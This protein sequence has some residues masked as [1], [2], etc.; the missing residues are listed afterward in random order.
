MT[1]S[2]LV[3]FITIITASGQK[4]SLS[5][6]FL[7]WAN[8][9]TLNVEVGYGF[10]NKLSADLHIRYNPW[11][12]HNEGKGYMQNRLQSYSVG[13]KYWPWYIY[14]GWF[15]GSSFQYSQYNRGGILSPLTREGDA[16]GVS[17]SGG[18]AYMINSRL[19]LLFGVSFWPGYEYYRLYSCPKCGDII[20]ESSALFFRLNE[21]MLQL[22][23]I[24]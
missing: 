20:E 19:N 7:E 13:V 15:V 17:L 14:S 22:T 6:N 21:V 9:A 18:Y 16:V 3:I 5:T 23:Y 4:L 10:T 1:L 12:F 2:T 11:Q 24:F 8:F